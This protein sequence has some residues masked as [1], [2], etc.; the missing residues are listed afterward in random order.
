[1]SLRVPR[2]TTRARSNLDA[3]LAEDSSGSRFERFAFLPYIVF[4][5]IVGIG[6]GLV[7]LAVL[8]SLR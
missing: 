2:I 5:V 1:M 4:L 6:S 7:V 3:P 8:F